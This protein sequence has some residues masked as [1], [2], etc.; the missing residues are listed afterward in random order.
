MLLKNDYKGRS[1][2]L[3]TDI[4]INKDVNHGNTQ[5]LY[6]EY[7]NSKLNYSSYSVPN[8]FRSRLLTSSNDLDVI[9]RM[10][11]CTAEKFPSDQFAHS[12]SS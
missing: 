11:A 4:L 9:S 3:K 5:A 7:N 8:I 6:E 1:A 12:A 10:R 2:G